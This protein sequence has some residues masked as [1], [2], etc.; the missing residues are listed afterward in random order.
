MHKKTHLSPFEANH[1]V[2]AVEFIAAE[3][4]VLLLRVS[5]ESF[6]DTQHLPLCCRCVCVG[7]GGGVGVCVCACVCVGV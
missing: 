7:G 1:L 3:P 6:E 2:E 4:S 5:V